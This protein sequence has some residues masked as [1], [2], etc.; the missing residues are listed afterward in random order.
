MAVF[1]PRVTGLCV[2]NHLIDSHTMCCFVTQR[3]HRQ[4][5]ADENEVY[6]GSI[7]NLCR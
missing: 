6:S 1:A 2:M 7:Q 4:A 5:V 3:Y